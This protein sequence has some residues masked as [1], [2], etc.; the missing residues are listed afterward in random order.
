MSFFER[1]DP[2]L[3]S[4]ADAPA[5]IVVIRTIGRHA[6]ALIICCVIAAAAYAG[7]V[8][9][10]LHGVSRTS[11]VIAVHGPSS[12]V[13]I[14]RDGRDVPHVRARNDWDLYFGEGYAQGSDR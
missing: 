1:P 10:G 3:A 6:V 12:V 8:A 7:D 2:R 9:Y 11:G 14:V 5:T 4:S 13:T